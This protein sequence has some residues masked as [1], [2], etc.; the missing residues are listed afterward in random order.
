MITFLTASGVASLLDL[1]EDAWRQAWKQRFPRRAR[2]STGDSGRAL[3]IYARRVVEEL[4]VGRGWDV[5]YPR[6][7]WRLNWASAKGPRRGAST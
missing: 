6:D 4:Q 7:V 3:L 1:D 5:E 2:P